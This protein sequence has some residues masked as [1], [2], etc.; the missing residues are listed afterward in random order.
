MCVP[1]VRIDIVFRDYVV[2]NAQGRRQGEIAAQAMARFHT[3]EEARL[4]GISARRLEHDRITPG[5]C[6]H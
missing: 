6:S 4:A 3:S 5:V 1:L 2:A